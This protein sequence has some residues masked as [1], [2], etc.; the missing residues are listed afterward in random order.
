LIIGQQSSRGSQVARKPATTEWH[1]LTVGNRAAP[2]A[3]A[4]SKIK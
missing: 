3:L 4:F 1:P 2:P